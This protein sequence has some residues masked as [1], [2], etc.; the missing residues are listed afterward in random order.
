MKAGISTESNILRRTWAEIDLG[1]LKE[2]FA[3]VRSACNR[4]VYAVVKADAYGHGAVPVASA[5][6]QAGVD[7]FAV[8]NLV[9]AEELRS[10]GIDAPILILG[11]TPVDCAQ[12]LVQG[13]IAQCVYSMEY[14][15]ALNAQA[16][17]A[18][19]V[20]TAHLKLDTGMGRIGFDFRSDDAPGFADAKKVLA[21][22]HLNTVGIFM[23][24]AV[25]DSEAP[26]DRAF[27]QAQYTRFWNAVE[28]LEK[29][30][31][32]QVRHCCNSAAALGLQAEKGDAVRAGIILY[33]LA[34]SDEVELPR[35]IRP[36]MSLYS[37]VSMIKTIAPAQTVSYGRTYAAPDAKRVATVCAGY[38]DG[39]PR[40][41][42]NKGSVLIHGKRAP[43]VG[44]VCMDQFCVDVT[45]IPDV[46]IG[47]V[48]TIWGPGLPVEEVAS[49]AQT[50]NYEIVCGISKRVPRKYIDP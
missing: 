39:V 38:A 25:A 19:I 12:R 46:S 32:F 7:G 30:H 45:D 10:A 20:V 23:H 11:Y 27:T 36:V 4:S 2:N 33:G 37:V 14:A 18:G 22:E 21:L 1:V 48:V 17:E 41:L 34:P 13:N 40:L 29:E 47:D 24:F 6:C 26:S 49:I 5:L 50:I 8:S 35:S 31:P 9:E 43:I 28:A 42:S 3:A 15:Q 44:R 16:K